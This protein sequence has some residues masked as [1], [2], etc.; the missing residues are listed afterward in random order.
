MGENQADPIHTKYENSSHNCLQEMLKVWY[1]STTDPSW[2]MIIDA[3]EKMKETR[4]I[5]SI[6][7]ECLISV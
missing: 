6:K 4:V 2:Q 3:L 7:E 5:E 1:E